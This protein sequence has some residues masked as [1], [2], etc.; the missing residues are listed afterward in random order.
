MARQPRTISHSGYYH[1]MLRGNGRMVIFSDDADRRTFLRMLSERLHATSIKL[2]AW[3]LMENHVHLLL[4]DQNGEFVDMMHSLETSY[5]RYFNMKTGHVGSVFQGRFKSKAIETDDY[6]LQA[7]RYIHDNPLDRGISRSSYPWSSYREYTGVPSLITPEPILELIGGRGGF[8]EFSSNSGRDSY[9]FAV[10]RNAND[11]ELVDQARRA[12]KGMAPH[13]VKTLPA[14]QRL[15][16]L[17]L[18][19]ASGFSI[20]KIERVTGLGR[21][22]IQRELAKNARNAKDPEARMSQM[23]PT[24]LT[25]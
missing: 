17:T 11:T 3:C 8:I 10:E 12:L 1:V 5:A 15:A 9:T 2:I 18:L 22:L 14:Q 23:N 16:C 4:S 6:L 19:K 21:N 24:P 25:R 13:L 7:V 20:R